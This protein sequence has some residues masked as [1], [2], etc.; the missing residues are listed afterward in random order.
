MAVVMSVHKGIKRIAEFKLRARDDRQEIA[1]IQN[2]LLC[3]LASAPEKKKKH[4]I[5]M[6]EEI[7]R[8]LN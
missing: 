7:D 5:E 8:I 3:R 1:E 4:M 6:V 2:D